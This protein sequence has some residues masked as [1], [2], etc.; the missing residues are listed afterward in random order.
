LKSDPAS[1]KHHDGDV[2]SNLCC[3][4]FFIPVLAH[5]FSLSINRCSFNQAKPKSECEARV[6]EAL[7]HKNWGTSST[8]MNEIARD[9]YDYDKCKK[10]SACSLWLIVKLLY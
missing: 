9:T 3:C 8:L 10:V 7:S 1:T 6:Y 5:L 4:V 2:A